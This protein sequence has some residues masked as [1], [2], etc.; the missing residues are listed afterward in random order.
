M[1]YRW[2]KLSNLCSIISHGSRSLM[3]LGL[4]IVE[5]SWSHSDTPHSVGFLRASDR[6]VVET[7]F[8]NTQHLQERDIH[9]AGGIRTCNPS[10]GTA[11][12]PR[13][14]PRGHWDQQIDVA[15]SSLS[16]ASSW[17][18]CSLLITKVVRTVT[19]LWDRRSRVC[20]LEVVR[21]FF[22]LSK[23]S[24]QNQGRTRPHIQCVPW[25]CSPRMQATG[26]WSTNDPHAMPSLKMG[27]ALPLGP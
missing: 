17:F 10:K 14:R 6:P 9:A 15:W 20:V 19:R 16:S 23:M 13:H 3:G 4:L 8:D 25:A 5:L 7:C 1:K 22:L 24:G 21:Y 18:R 12:N 11:A 26:A 2:Q 27:G